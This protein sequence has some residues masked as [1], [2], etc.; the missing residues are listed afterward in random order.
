MQNIRIAIELFYLYSFLGFLWETLWVS[1]QKGA[2]VQRG[3]LNGPILPIYGFGALAVTLAT[4]VVANSDWQVFLVGM[5][6]ATLLELITGMMI[7]KLFHVRYWDYDDRPFNY[8]GYICLRSTLFWGVMSV[9]LVEIFNKELLK[10][11]GWFDF[12]HSIWILY[13]VLA[14]TAVDVFDSVRD[15]LTLRGLLQRE[16]EVFDYVEHIISHLGIQLEQKKREFLQTLENISDDGEQ[17]TREI[18]ELSAKSLNQLINGRIAVKIHREK[19]LKNRLIE[20]L[21]GNIRKDILAEASQRALQR[22]DI[23]YARRLKQLEKANRRMKQLLKRND[24]T[25]RH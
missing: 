14:L 25:Y 8:K 15:A 10:L 4:R 23:L 18:K 9:V 24:L 2:W 17:L 21:Q 19:V 3:F 11:I 1:Y 22:T 7:E 5:V 16:E 13:G 6:V 12:P 20:K